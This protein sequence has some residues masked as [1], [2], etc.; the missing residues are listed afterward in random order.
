[1]VDGSGIYLLN[2][3]RQQ[4]VERI[5]GQINPLWRAEADE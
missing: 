1:M 3:A 5:A 2:D 4:P